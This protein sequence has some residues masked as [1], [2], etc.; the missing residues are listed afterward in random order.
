MSAALVAQ[1]G[2]LLLGLGAV[3]G[4]L[5]DVGRDRRAVAGRR[6]APGSVQELAMVLV[7][8]LSVVG[9]RPCRGGGCAGEA[10]SLSLASSADSS[11]S[12]VRLA[13]GMREKWWRASTALRRPGRERGGLPPT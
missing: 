5:G 4:Q 6:R 1:T 10:A 7:A 12:S 13:D 2:V 11:R 8:L 3:V 9:R